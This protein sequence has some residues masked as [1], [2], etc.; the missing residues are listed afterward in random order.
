MDSLEYLA[1]AEYAVTPGRV[2]LPGMAEGD[3]SD[4]R[5]NEL[6]DFDRFKDF[7]IRPSR[8]F[9]PNDYGLYGLLEACGSGALMT[10]TRPFICGVRAGCPIQ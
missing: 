8:T 10:M 7:S 6:A 5:L 3:E 2:I 9:P 1:A 4:L